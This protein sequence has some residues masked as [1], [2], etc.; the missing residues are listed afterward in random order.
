MNIFAGDLLGDALS[1][2]GNNS[3]LAAFAH[4]VDLDALPGSTQADCVGQFA[5]IVY[6]FVIDT[7]N[8]VV[9]AQ[10]CRFRRRARL[11]ACNQGSAL[12]L[13]A[14]GF[15]GFLVDRLDGSA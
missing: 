6:S 12:D 7:D 8:D 2:F 15:R 4:V 11:D 14:Q 10:S 3:A 1:E 9:N 5:V 13:R